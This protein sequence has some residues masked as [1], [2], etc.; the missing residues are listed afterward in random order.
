MLQNRF[1]TIHMNTPRLGIPLFSNQ[2]KSYGNGQWSANILTL[3]MMPHHLQR[4]LFMLEIPFETDTR[5]LR[6]IIRLSTGEEGG[7]CDGCVVKN[8][9]VYGVGDHVCGDGFSEFCEPTIPREAVHEVPDVGD[10]SSFKAYAVG[11]EPLWD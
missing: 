11:K 4:V 10:V 2:E 6:W 3:K 1:K 9:G 5:G 7:Y 8:R